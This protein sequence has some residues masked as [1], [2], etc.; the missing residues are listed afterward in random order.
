M[1]NYRM[2]HYSQMEARL[3]ADRLKRQGAFEVVISETS[4]GWDVTWKQ[5]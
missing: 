3:H 4:Q 5:R 2:S 1:N